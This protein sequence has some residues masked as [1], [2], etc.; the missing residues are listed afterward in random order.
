MGGYDKISYSVISNNLCLGI[1]FLL[2]FKQTENNVNFQPTY[3]HKKKKI[4]GQDK[5]D[6][7]TIIGYY[8]QYLIQ[9]NAIYSAGH[10]K[11]KSVVN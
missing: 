1:I 4:K 8:Y 6:F 10:L 2:K 9:S 11:K 3:A 5:T 7:F